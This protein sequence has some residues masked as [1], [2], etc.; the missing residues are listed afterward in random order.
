MADSTNPTNL[1]SF[2]LEAWH[3]LLQFIQTNTKE[4]LACS[5]FLSVFFVWKKSDICYFSHVW[6][7]KISSGNAPFECSQ[8]ASCL[9]QL[10]CNYAPQNFFI[11]TWGYSTGPFCLFERLPF[12]HVWLKHLLLVLTQTHTHAQLNPMNWINANTKNDRLALLSNKKQDKFVCTPRGIY[13]DKEFTHPGF[14]WC[15]HY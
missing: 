11:N 15:Y 12:S 13:K 9:I 5:C 1:L 4:I 6:I 8:F 14:F 10:V 2:F 3:L 7:I